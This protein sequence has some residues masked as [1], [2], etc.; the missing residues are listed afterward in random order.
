MSRL[1]TVAAKGKVRVV[2]F[3]QA[4]IDFGIS[5]FDDGQLTWCSVKHLTGETNKRLMNAGLF[6]AEVVEI[7][8]PDYV[9]YEDIQYQTTTAY[10]GYTTFKVLAELKGIVGYELDK[11]GVPNEHVLNKVWQAKYGIRGRGRAE[12]KL[13]VISKVKFLYPHLT[14]VTDDIADAVLIGKYGADKIAPQHQ[15]TSLF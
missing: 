12:Q 4:T 14:N 3:D 7:L 9:I 1:D 8:Q 15:I 5:V 6:V 11:A 13:N 2:G 10:S